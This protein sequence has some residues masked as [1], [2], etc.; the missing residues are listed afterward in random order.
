[1]FLIEYDVN[2]FIDGERVEWIDI[3]KKSI[4]K[5]TL[6]GDTSIYNVKKGC[7]YSFVN[8]LQA[9]NGNSN[10]ESVYHKLNKE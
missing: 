6:H 10:I 5:F 7:Q 1:M 4:V 9:L 2:I 3:S 8:N